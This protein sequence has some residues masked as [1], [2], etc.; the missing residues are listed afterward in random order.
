MRIPT[1]SLTNTVD[2]NT[3][4]DLPG[5]GIHEQVFLMRQPLRS[6]KRVTRKYW[7]GGFSLLAQVYGKHSLSFIWI[8]FVFLK[9][10]ASFCRL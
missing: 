4:K 5:A 1:S 7:N 6:Y 10:F 3:I 8:L 9:F 2:E